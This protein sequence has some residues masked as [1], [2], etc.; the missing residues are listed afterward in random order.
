MGIFNRLGGR[1]KTAPLR[2]N[3]GDRGDSD[4]YSV[5]SNRCGFAVLDLETTGLSPRANR[6][7]QIAVVV[8]DPSGV[9][10]SKW[11]SLVNPE[12]PIEATHI[13]GLVD[14]DVRHA[15]KFADIADELREILQGFALVAHNL[16]FDASFLDAEYSRLG[17]AVPQM[18]TVCTLEESTFFLPDLTRRRLEDCCRAIGVRPGKHDAVSDAT[19]TSEL[20]AYYLDTARRDGVREELL[21]YPE[22]AVGIT[23]STERSENLSLNQEARKHTRIEVQKRRP[24]EA[25][26]TL[27][28]SLEKVSLEGLLW[29]DAPSG[30]L[31][32]L[33]LV[34]TVIED[35]TVTNDEAQQLSDLAEAFALNQ[36]TSDRLK[37]RLLS[38]VAAQAW[39]DGHLSRHEQVEIKE[40]AVALGLSDKSATT[41][42][43]SAEA[44]RQAGLSR[45]LPAL[46]VD[47]AFGEPLRVGSRIA[48]TGCDWEQRERLELESVARGCR[49]TGSV[50]AKTDFLVTDGSYVGNKRDAAERL[51][52]RIIHPDDF[53]TLLRWI[54][55]SL[56]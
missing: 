21:L 17:F 51:G 56:H 10:Q 9:V 27:K 30:S 40:L 47:W 44:D 31:Q 8:T 4:P 18:P 1:G 24:R 15:P 42:L 46:P 19:A 43:K 54:Q 53:E 52:T 38:I 2:S 33:E 35:S 20:L 28:A 12:G 37:E 50:S 16:R 22:T 55:P 5:L 11:T 34:R 29:D 14:S 45:D 49:L 32:Y 41:L 25:S 48:F 7:V 6:I 3:G 23:W 39:S 13:H 26:E 36:G